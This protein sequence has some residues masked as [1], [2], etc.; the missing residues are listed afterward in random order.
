METQMNR[1]KWKSCHNRFPIVTVNPYNTELLEYLSNYFRTDHEWLS[2]LLFSEQKRTSLAQLIIS[3]KL[4]ISTV[5]PASFRVM[6]RAQI[7]SDWS[8]IS[9]EE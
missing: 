6:L 9:R 2:G 5:G 3:C 8:R 7:E 1:E 4:E